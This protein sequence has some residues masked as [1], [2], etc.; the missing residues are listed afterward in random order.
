MNENTLFELDGLEPE[1]E[2][3]LTALVMGEAS[4]LERDQ[5]EMLL[6]ERADAAAWY[7]Q[8]RQLHAGLMEL[9][10]IEADAVAEDVGFED[11]G[12]EDAAQE[13]ASNGG[14]KLSADRR[15]KVL[16]VLDGQSPN[17][18]GAEDGTKGN[19]E[20]DRVEKEVFAN[21]TVAKNSVQLAAKPS[22]S[23]RLYGR[24]KLWLAM[25]AA[26]MLLGVGLW[27]LQLSSSKS[28]VA[29]FRQR[30]GRD[31]AE[32]AL[33]RSM[34]SG[35]DAPTTALPTPYFLNDDY[36]RDEVQYLPP[37]L[38]RSERGD[39][40]SDLLSSENDRVLGL[41]LPAINAEGGV[42]APE[43]AAAATDGSFSE[44]EGGIGMGGGMGGYG[45]QD[46]S[47][48][49]GG[50][51]GEGMQEGQRLGETYSGEMFGGRTPGMDGE[52][53]QAGRG[54]E[55]QEMAQSGSTARGSDTPYGVWGEVALPELRG[56]TAM[57]FNQPAD[58]PVADGYGLASASDADETRSLAEKE[59]LLR[60]D[61]V[62]GKLDGKVS[63]PD[64][65]TILLGGIKRTGNESTVEL[66]ASTE[67]Q[68]LA[69][70]ELFSGE[71]RARELSESLGSGHPSVV[72]LRKRIEDTKQQINSQA[73]ADLGESE[74]IDAAAT[75]EL[76]TDLRTEDKSAIQ[77]DRRSGLNRSAEVDGLSL[78]GLNETAAAG[79][80]FSTFSLH[81]SDV[82]FKLA[83][84]A[85]SRGE[86]PDPAKIR[87]EEFVN[88]MDYRDPL[89]TQ[90]EQVACQ[91]EQA[92]HPYLMQ[93]NLLRISLRTAA[94]GRSQERPLRLTLLLDNSGSMERP[95]RRQTVRRAF[96]ALAQQLTPNDQVTLIGFANTPRL[97]AERVSGDKLP[98]L[99][100]R[101]EDLPSEGGTNLEAALRLAMEK[102]VEQA[103]LA[104]SASAGLNRIVLMTDGA[105]NLGDA[106]PQ[107]LSEL[108]TQM[109]EAGIAFDATGISA[110]E[111][112]D[113]VLE[114]LAR[115]GDGRYYLLDASEDAGAGFADQIAGAL[116]PA[117]K[118]VKVQVEFN[119]Q[120][121]GQYKLLGFEKH[122]LNPED[123]RN[124]QVDAAELAAAEAGVAVYHF[125]PKP[126]GRG[127]VGSVSVRYQDLSSGLMVE[128][129]WPIPY[130][131]QTPRLEQADPRIR[132]ASV[133]ALFA[134][135]LRGDAVAYGTDLKELAAILTGLPSSYSN[136]LR[137]EQL[138]NMI[139]AAR[140]LQP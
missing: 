112:N 88:A 40:W 12:F 77:P 127:D 30:F 22:W 100:Q 118:N 8:L 96:E 76:R 3:R 104:G 39:R 137:V 63:V 27:S 123:F 48:G 6:Q 75:D 130:Q 35:I 7:R 124:D 107:R 49:M 129:R 109:R 19:V 17:P 139:E 21:S 53:A 106:D 60:E 84:A 105:V 103:R 102:S 29:S 115:Q 81:V 119:P 140:Q 108:V 87:I 97:L 111:L 98:E 56:G 16:A 90:Q 113:E 72:E 101:V 134:A 110:L 83:S 2:L 26:C 80:R 99:V 33:A 73:Q 62:L 9:A 1:L 42:L 57:T 85:L 52:A 20:K 67:S 78:E 46:D 93:R 86:W 68:R 32:P 28:Q 43:A 31:S 116:R 136:S 54:L 132:I 38:R 82:S 94:T 138:R 117:A 41:A 125:E 34:V 25:V 37:A 18:L 121:V 133:A 44:G 11:A 69:H 59:L 14:W 10:A 89:A 51:G 24:R 95:D 128:R 131:P 71:Q 5:L 15:H 74:S 61:E 36:L 66:R 4:D 92:I 55:R 13:A 65:G 45:G 135:K 64:G 70:S 79:E 91:L 126:D 122:L 23:R 58:A 114:A 50:M 120:R 47:M